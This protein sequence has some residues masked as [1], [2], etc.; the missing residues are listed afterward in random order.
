MSG[1]KIAVCDSSER[2]AVKVG[3]GGN[4]MVPMTAAPAVGGF[5]SVV[6]VAA[7]APQAAD[8]IVDRWV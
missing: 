4:G 6:V 5:A 2:V 1:G 7:A 3:E 8:W